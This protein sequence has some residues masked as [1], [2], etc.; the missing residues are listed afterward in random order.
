MLSNEHFVNSFMY[1]ILDVPV[2][3]RDLEFVLDCV[4]SKALA[5]EEL[6]SCSAE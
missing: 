5:A 6:L 4:L 1:I 2:V 3:E